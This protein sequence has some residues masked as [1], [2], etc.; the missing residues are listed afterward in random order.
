M[1]HAPSG[2]L[3]VRLRV[4]RRVL[5]HCPRAHA[6]AQVQTRRV[7]EDH[8]S[9]TRTPPHPQ[10]CHHV[11]HHELVEGVAQGRQVCII[12]DRV[13]QVLLPSLGRL[14][15]RGHLGG[16]HT[17]ASTAHGSTAH[18]ACR[19]ACDRAHNGVA[20]TAR[21]ATTALQDRETA[22]LRTAHS[23]VSL[24]LHVAQLQT[25]QLPKPSSFSTI[26][27]DCK[28]SSNSRR[29]DQARRKYSRE[30]AKPCQP[31]LL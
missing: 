5:V 30:Q 18:G 21:T 6:E 22:R 12:A 31:Q 25:R 11:V 24:A 27:R 20:G 17:S 19:R 10:V 9:C 15:D 16:S 1:A 7:T 14:L 29:S 13:L 28:S 26:G 4:T 23:R 2:E 8:S 3:P